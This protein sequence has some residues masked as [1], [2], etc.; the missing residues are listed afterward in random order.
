MAL[1]DLA[2]KASLVTYELPDDEVASLTDELLEAQPAEPVNGHVC[3]RVPGTSIYANLGRKVEEQ[4]FLEWFNNNVP[5]M[6]QEYGPFEENSIFNIDIDVTRRTPAGVLRVIYDNGAGLK[7]FNDVKNGPPHIDTEEAMIFHGITDLAKCW[8]VG[9][10]AVTKEYRGKASDQLVS[11]ALY[12]ALYSEAKDE[13]IEHFVSVLDKAAF[14]GLS[15]LGVPFKSL[16]GSD[17]F[18]YLGSDESIAVYGRVNEFFKDMTEYKRR[19]NFMKR[20]FLGPYMDRL[21]FGSGVPTVA[22]V[23]L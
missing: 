15:L 8:D 12:R 4:V 9:T 20:H 13:E 18:S 19:L 23:D 1:P 6:E 5:T 17:Y 21:M 10:L 7:S 22:E 16:N 2:P 11:T 3:Y 14:K